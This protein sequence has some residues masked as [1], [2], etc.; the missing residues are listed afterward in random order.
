MRKIYELDEKDIKQIVAEYFSV[1]EDS[2][3]VECTTETRFYGPE[4]YEVPRVKVKVECY[5]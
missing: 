3:Q 4:E 1:L 2:V 5:E